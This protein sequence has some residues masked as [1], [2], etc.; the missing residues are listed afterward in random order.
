MTQLTSVYGLP[1]GWRDINPSY[2]ASRNPY[3]SSVCTE[4][5]NQRHPI[6]FKRHNR[7]QHLVVANEINFENSNISL[8]NAL[9]IGRGYGTGAKG[10]SSGVPGLDP[11]R[12]GFLVTRHI[13]TRR[14]F[15]LVG[16]SSGNQ[17]IK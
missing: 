15:G 13:L 1:P 16:K 5:K 2:T 10:L 8:R 7:G 4:V 14:I 3:I 9:S 11:C 17:T 6:A 12:I